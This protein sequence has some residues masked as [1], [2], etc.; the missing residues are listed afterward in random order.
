MK[1][2]VI[3][4]SVDN[5]QA[6]AGVRRLI[7][8]LGSLGKAAGTSADASEKAA[9]RLGK[10]M[11]DQ[12]R[13]ND[14]AGDNSARA[15]AR[16]IGTELALIDRVGNKRVDQTDRA[17]RAEERFGDQARQSLVRID[18]VV[19]KQNSR[20]QA[21]ERV[22]AIEQQIAI[23]TAQ[24]AANIDRASRA[25]AL[26][27]PDPCCAGGGGG[28]G[29]GGAG[30]KGGGGKGG[31]SG[32]GFGGAVAT[33]I[34]AAAAPIAISARG[35]AQGAASLTERT[36]ELAAE[37]LE[38]R[39]ALR[40]LAVI[41]GKP[42]TNEFV[43]SHADFA[44]RTG[45]KMNEATTFQES[46]LNYGQAR[47]GKS[48]T[49][50]QFKDMDD[51]VGS[52]VAQR[53]I[54][55]NAMGKLSGVLLGAKDYSG[56]GAKG[57]RQAASDVGGIAAV[58]DRGAGTA[59]VLVGQTAE[60][61]A[62]HRDAKSLFRSPFQ[63]VEEIPAVVSMFAESNEQEAR[64]YT[65]NLLRLLENPTKKQKPGL[66][67]AGIVPGKTGFIDSLKKLGPLLEK[68]AAMKDETLA[69]AAAEL[70]P[71]L[72][73]RQVR[74][75]SVAVQKGL[76]AGPDGTPGVLEDRLEFYKKY[77]VGKMEADR[78]EFRA[79]GAGAERLAS[80]ATTRTDLTVGSSLS[81]VPT[82]R[83]QAEN[84][85]KK[86]GYFD[87]MFTRV[88]D[89]IAD[90]LGSLL[91]FGSADS[92]MEARIAYRANSIL[93]KRGAPARVGNDTSLTG[94]GADQVLARRAAAL[95]GM[96]GNPLVD[97][98]AVAEAAQAARSRASAAGDGKGGGELAVEWL[99]QQYA[100]MQKTNDLLRQMLGMG[101][102][103]A[104][105]GP[106]VGRQVP[107]P[108]RRVEPPRTGAVR[109]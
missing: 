78:K 102:R 11:S 51:L 99:R 104:T 108:L 61:L 70:F 23:C 24:T 14:S 31:G 20:A 32:G 98:G 88:T 80:A 35:A 66:Q 101:G 5:S 42:I 38:Q 4:V 82:L 40:N 36:K 56:M 95:E 46:L 16:R 25:L 58:L 22:R 74:G 8:M 37:F 72:D 3:K 109:P 97:G 29:G 107:S 48:I 81:A 90:A 50:A 94:G 2:H 92:T 49:A 27:G 65:D 63:A 75:L 87:S 30:G 33:A 64:M 15:T 7:T 45:L 34:T 91:T 21:G 28:G 85:L 17:R 39:D 52:M 54:D 19:S 62:E 41:Q 12:A 68:M 76:S 60:L 1:E 77:D 10:A 105:S 57:G 86:E 96:G 71:D 53:G 84:E 106:G 103:S 13:R 89:G 43:L 59:Q 18:Q 47:I 79:S 100:E 67:K 26:R 55:P 69:A 9:Q 93:D 44:A 6:E 73:I 83:Q